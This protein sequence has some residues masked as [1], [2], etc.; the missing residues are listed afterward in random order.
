MK[1]FFE[2]CQLLKQEQAGVPP[3][4]NVTPP[5]GTTLAGPTPPKPLAGPTPPKPPAGPTPPKPPTGGQTGNLISPDTARALK[6]A[7]AIAERE[8]NQD[9][10]ELLRRRL[11]DSR[12]SAVQYIPADKVT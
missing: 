4:G 9:V 6:N 11:Q 10:V 8:R 12:V 7:L 2:F 5:Y 1:S 3:V